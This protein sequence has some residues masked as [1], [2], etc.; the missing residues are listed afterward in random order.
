MS[1]LAEL[2]ID[3]VPLPELEQR[4]S[5]SRTSLKNRAKLLGVQLIRE[6][7]TKSVWP[8]DK[9]E[10]GDRYHQHLRTGGNSKDFQ[11]DPTQRVKRRKGGALSTQAAG[12]DGVTMQAFVQELKRQLQPTKPTQRAMELKLMATEELKLTGPELS[13]LLSFNVGKDFDGKTRFGYR[14]WRVENKDKS[15]FKHLWK[16]EGA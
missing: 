3:D 12:A 11:V 5:I 14:F 16:C 4:W 6:S 10:L 13:D 9:I 7:S 15:R 1:D 8:G 2:V